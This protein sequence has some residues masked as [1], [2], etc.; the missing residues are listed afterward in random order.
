MFEPQIVRNWQRRLSGVDEIV[1]SLYAKVLRTCRLGRM[2]RG[3]PRIAVLQE[4]IGD[5]PG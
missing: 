3:R 2:E 5:V 1:S 4:I